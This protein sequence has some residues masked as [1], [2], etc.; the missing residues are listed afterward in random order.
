QAQNVR[1]DQ[2]RLG[3][4]R[5][6]EGAAESCNECC[7]SSGACRRLD[8]RCTHLIHER[9]R[10]D[11]RMSKAILKAHFDGQHI[12]LDEPFELTKDVSLLVAVQ[13]ENTEAERAELNRLAAAGL[14]IA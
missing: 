7:G 10:G 9:E 4:P 11:Y 12:V 13:S 5:R 2:R 1:P 8:Q 3:P 14:S 6:N